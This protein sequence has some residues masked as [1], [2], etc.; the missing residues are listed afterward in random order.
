MRKLSIA[1]F[2]CALFL[3][4]C[5][6]QNMEPIQV[7]HIAPF[8][9]DEARIGQHEK[10]GILLAV[11]EVNHSDNLI[12]GRRVLVR[13]VDSR[14]VPEVAAADAVRLATLNRVTALLGGSDAAQTTQIEQAARPYGLPLIAFS[15]I[16][17][18]GRDEA[19]FSLALS[20]AM[21]GQAL[22]RHVKD[23]LKPRPARVLVVVDEPAGRARDL[24]DAFQ[25]ELKGADIKIDRASHK[26]DSDIAELRREITGAAPAAVLL[27]GGSAEFVKKFRTID[28]A[29]EPQIAWLYGG[30]DTAIA[31]LEQNPAASR[32]MYFATA[33]VVEAETERGKE[34]VRKYREEFKE[35]PDI[36]A[37]LGYDSARCLF[38]AMKASSVLEPGKVRDQLEA[39]ERFDCLTGEATFRKGQM[40]KRPIFIVQ[41][42]GDG[43]RLVERQSDGK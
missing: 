19:P 4:A 22:A 40:V 32:D 31:A 34:F 26:S 8:S 12:Q 43:P 38:D 18:P 14:G 27:A 35:D 15:N 42:Q 3:P 25:Q 13:H 2:L 9:G 39:M 1:V 30:E 41:M 28:N 11:A 5:S 21:Q 17:E 10:Q 37:A 6:R 20:A 33:Y 7:G 23:G 24:A 16:A 29:P 36:Q